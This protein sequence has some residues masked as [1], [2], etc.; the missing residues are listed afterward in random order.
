M[1][2]NMDTIYIFV[3]NRSLPIFVNVLSIKQPPSF[4][5]TTVVTAL[6]FRHIV[7]KT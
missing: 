7:F 1:S 3:E 6:Q 5:L 4:I 2:L